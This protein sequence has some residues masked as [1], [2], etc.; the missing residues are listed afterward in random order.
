MKYRIA[1]GNIVDK[2]WKF[3]HYATPEEIGSLRV[4][5]TGIVEYLAKQH[6]GYLWQD[7]SDTHK[8]EWGCDHRGLELYENDIV[9]SEYYPFYDPYSDTYNYH[10]VIHY[11]NELNQFGIRYVLVNKDRLGIND[12]TVAVLDEFYDLIFLGNLNENP[13]LIER[14]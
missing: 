5:R 10:G 2:E 7:V 4:S 3:D 1:I 12:G 11:C 9:K 6:F 13:E 8:V 14:K